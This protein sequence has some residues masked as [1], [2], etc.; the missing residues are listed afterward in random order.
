M[1]GVK[2]TKVQRFKSSSLV[3]CKAG[4][5]NVFFTD[6]LVQNTILR[7]VSHV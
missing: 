7:A 5:G 3:V 6:N 4:T 1:A 2:G